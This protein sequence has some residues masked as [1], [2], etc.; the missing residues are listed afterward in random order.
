MGVLGT[1]L[2]LPVAGPIGAL[3]WIAQQVAESAITQMLDPARIETALL[4]L[5]RQLETGK[6]TEEEF[7][8]EEARL[9]EELAEMRAISAGETAPEAEEPPAEPEPEGT[10]EPQEDASWTVA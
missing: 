9:L 7:E 5:E 8:I 3:R 10:P 1:L 2:G 6:I 4:S